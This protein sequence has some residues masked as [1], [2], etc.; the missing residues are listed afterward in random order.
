MVLAVKWKDHGG[1]RSGELREG[2]QFF[3]R[4]VRSAYGP[5]CERENSALV[6]VE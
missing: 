2:K 3:R 5:R 4:W 1:S 6:K